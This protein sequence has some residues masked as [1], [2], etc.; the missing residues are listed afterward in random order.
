M[1]IRFSCPNGHKL[2]VKDHL[3]GKRGICPSCR[4]TFLIPIASQAREPATVAGESA[5]ATATSLHFSADAT[6]GSK[7]VVIPVVDPAMRAAPGLSRAAGASAASTVTAAETPRAAVFATDVAIPQR[8]AAGDIPEASSARF[9]ARRM[10]SRRNQTAIAIALL[11]A[12]IL[13]AVVLMW[14]LSRGPE[15]IDSATRAPISAILAEDNTLALA[16]DMAAS[17]LELQ[18]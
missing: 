10:R 2:N 14:V 12:V 11:I 13:L 7:S 6:P 8:V 4:A 17:I 16:T 3:A 18:T 5:T 15:A 1:G 9:I